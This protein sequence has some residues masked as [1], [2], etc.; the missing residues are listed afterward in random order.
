MA[1]CNRDHGLS[2]Q[3]DAYMTTIEPVVTG[4]TLVV[5][6]PIPYPCELQA[7]QLNAGGISGSPAWTLSILRFIAGSGETT[8]PVGLSGILVL[9]HGTSGSQGYSLYA[10]GSSQ[11]QMLQGDVLKIETSGSNAAVREAQMTIVV[12][13]LQD[14]V[15]HF[16]LTT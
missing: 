4:A 11:V 3:R 14:I 10:S 1:I 7:V 6:G 15:S 2:E 13:K 5:S 9:A 8:I 12:K 16:G